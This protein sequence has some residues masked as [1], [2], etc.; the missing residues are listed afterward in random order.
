MSFIQIESKGSK[1]FNAIRTNTNDEIPTRIWSTVKGVLLSTHSLTSHSSLFEG[2][3][4]V[5][6]G[7]Q[8]RRQASSV[9]TWP[10]L[11]LVICSCRSL[12]R[13]SHFAANANRRT[14][15]QRS[16]WEIKEHIQIAFIHSW[17]WYTLSAQIII[18]CFISLAPLMGRVG[19]ERG[20]LFPSFIL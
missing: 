3:K 6:A 4:N 8:P 19:Y 14:W 5:V 12:G 2:K 18:F 1:T 17:R 20:S 16:W 7:A 10:R 9:Q 15:V 11:L 13:S